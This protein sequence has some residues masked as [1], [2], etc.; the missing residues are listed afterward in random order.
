MQGGT[1]WLSDCNLT[2]VEDK[3][4]ME[5]GSHS[6][7]AGEWRKKAGNNPGIINTFKEP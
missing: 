5:Y 7:H 1:T 4:L 3:W 2:A 6:L